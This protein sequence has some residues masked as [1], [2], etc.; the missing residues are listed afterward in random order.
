[1]KFKYVPSSFSEK[2]FS[3]IDIGVLLES[4]IT[5]HGIKRY[6]SQIMTY[7]RIDEKNDKVMLYEN[8]MRTKNN[9]PADI[10]RKFFKEEISD[11]WIKKD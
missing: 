11:P 2:E 8:G 10:K 4:K 1:M 5:K 6:I 7:S 9:I 3:F